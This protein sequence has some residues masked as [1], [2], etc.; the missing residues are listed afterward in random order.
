MNSRKVKIKEDEDEDENE[1]KF[2]HATDAVRGTEQGV[3]LIATYSLLS[4]HTGAELLSSLLRYIFS[5]LA[6]FSAML[7]MA[8]LWHTAR[9]EVE[10]RF[11]VRAIL[12]LAAFFAAIS[13]MILT[14]GF[15]ALY[16]AAAPIIT[17]VMGSLKI[18]FNIGVTLWLAG[19]AGYFGE[20]IQHWF[21]DSTSLTAGAR[22]QYNTQI[23]KQIAIIT[24]DFM[25]VTAITVVQVLG[26]VGIYAT[27]GIVAGI[28]VLALIGVTTYN[29]FY[30]NTYQDTKNYLNLNLFQ[31][32]KEKIGAALCN[33]TTK[34]IGNHI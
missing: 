12:E 13:A 11:Y 32:V 6:L 15:G 14:F 30:P 16:A 33:M 20:N 4:S 5:P 31:P 22:A 1:N 10:I 23:K 9:Q 34:K 21:N 27:M 29:Y 2:K 8:S 3:Q 19:K 17:T 24:C 18:L 26:H 25:L 28:A 7:E